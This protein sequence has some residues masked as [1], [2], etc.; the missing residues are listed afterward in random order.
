MAGVQ[1]EQLDAGNANFREESAEL[2]D[3]RLRI[4]EAHSRIED[5]ENFEEALKEFKELHAE[6][7]SDIRLLRQRIERM[8]EAEA[9]MGR[10]AEHL[11]VLER[12][13]AEREGELNRKQTALDASR[14]AID[15]YSPRS[16]INLLLTGNDNP[17][18]NT[19]QVPGKVADQTPQQFPEKTPALTPET[20]ARTETSPAAS[21]PQQARPEDLRAIARLTAQLSDARSNVELAREEILRLLA[22][23]DGV[24]R[25]WLSGAVRRSEEW[26]GDPGGRVIQAQWRTLFEARQ[27]TFMEFS[28]IVPHTKRGAKQAVEEQPNLQQPTNDEAGH[29]PAVEAKSQSSKTREEDGQDGHSRTDSQTISGTAAAADIERKKEIEFS[30]NESPEDLKILARLDVETLRVLEQACLELRTIFEQELKTGST[31]IT[32]LKTATVADGSFVPRG[33]RP[34]AEVPVQPLGEHR[35]RILG[36]MPIT[37]METW[38]YLVTMRISAR[39]AFEASTPLLVPGTILLSHPFLHLSAAK[40]GGKELYEELRNLNSHGKEPISPGKR[41]RVSRILLEAR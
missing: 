11:R 12:S 32:H 39:Q 1:H 18:G 17:S 40:R 6:D 10:R 25:G 38:R 14:S 29:E 2:K 21:G 13:F 16:P 23:I 15:R 22:T 9:E 4:Y 26:A 33:D 27:I 37:R 5:F 30:F 19:A 24:Y 35:E 3:R 34:I 28:V 8:E 41:V 31:V 36:S 20:N 7:R